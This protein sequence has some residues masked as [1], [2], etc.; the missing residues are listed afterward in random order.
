MCGCIWKFGGTLDCNLQFISKVPLTVGLGTLQARNTFEH[1]SSSI[2]FLTKSMLKNHMNG[3]HGN[4]A[5]FLVQLSLSLRTNICI[6]GVP[7]NDLTPMKNC[8]GVQGRSY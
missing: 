3:Y 2:Q 7:I 8:P 5:F 6:S 4:H 1:I